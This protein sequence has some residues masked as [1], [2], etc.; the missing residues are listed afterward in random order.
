MS[1]R[2]RAVQG[3]GKARKPIPYSAGVLETV[4]RGRIE[5]DDAEFPDGLVGAVDNLMNNAGLI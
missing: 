3:A 4:R 5:A 2:E 1:Y